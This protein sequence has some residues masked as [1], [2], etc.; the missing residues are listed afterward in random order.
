MGISLIKH[1]FWGTPIYGKPHILYAYV[2][3]YIYVC[4]CVDP[5]WGVANIL[6]GPAWLSRTT[7]I[8]DIERSMRCQ[9]M[10]L[11]VLGALLLPVAKINRTDSCWPMLTPLPKQEKM[12][13]VNPNLSFSYGK[14]LLWPNRWRLYK[15]GQAPHLASSW[16]RK[17][18]PRWCTPCETSEKKEEQIQLLSG[19]AAAFTDIVV[20][21]PGCVG[22]FYSNHYYGSKSPTYNKT[23]KVS[24]QLLTLPNMPYWPCH[25]QS[26]L[27]GPQGLSVTSSLTFGA[28][29][30]SA[31]LP[32]PAFPAAWWNGS[33]N[34][35]L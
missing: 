28:A 21:I 8:D 20:E 6:S 2:Y 18:S 4:V 1:P 13:A 30:P 7:D 14:I 5:L 29:L 15:Q 16:R 12:I 24:V 3:I 11:Q 33:N 17:S 27:H 34:H 9:R 31:P 25:V 22:I 19:L 23:Y 32:L 35:R 10:P 26:Y